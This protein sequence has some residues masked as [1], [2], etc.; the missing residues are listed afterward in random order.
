MDCVDFVA[1]SVVRSGYDELY[2]FEDGGSWFRGGTDCRD[3]ASEL[4]Y[5]DDFV[6]VLAW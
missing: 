1:V 5:E 4:I 6:S 2:C 3:V